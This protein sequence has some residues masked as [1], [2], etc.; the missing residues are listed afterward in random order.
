MMHP[1]FPRPN[2]TGIAASSGDM[3]GIHV[4]LN[5]SSRLTIERIWPKITHGQKNDSRKFEHSFGCDQASD[6]TVS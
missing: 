3:E 6:R 5:V 4:N 1:E 2:G